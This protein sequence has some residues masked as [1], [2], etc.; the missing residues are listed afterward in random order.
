MWGWASIENRGE[1]VIIYEV[2]AINIQFGVS[3]VKDANS[4]LDQQQLNKEAVR[5]MMI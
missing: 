5:N 2:E 3:R 1:R 4:D